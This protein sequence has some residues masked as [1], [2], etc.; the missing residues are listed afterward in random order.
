MG[1]T[2]RPVQGPLKILRCK[3]E[4]RRRV[5]RSVFAWK[6]AGIPAAKLLIGLP[7]Y[8]Y[9]WRSVPDANNGLR[10]GGSPIHGDHSYR[11]IQT[12]IDPHPDRPAEPATVA[13][14]PTPSAAPANPLAPQLPSAEAPLPTKAVLYRD[15]VSQAPWL[16]D[17][18]SFWTFED[19]TSIRSKADFVTQ[20]QL[21]GFMV[22]ELG[23]DTPSATLLHAAHTALARPAATPPIAQ[24]PTQST[25]TR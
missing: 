3:V 17:G 18:D 21:G 11:F 4:I 13:V 7:F 15:P 10:Q 1:P 25:R 9:G 6:A 24:R 5:E 14:V 2:S 20:E 22:W 16:F 12:L 19:P 8:A 23:E